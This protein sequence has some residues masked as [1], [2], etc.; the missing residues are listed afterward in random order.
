ML[1]FRGATLAGALVYILPTASAQI[2]VAAGIN[3][4]VA[5]QSS[6]WAANATADKSID[7]NRDGRWAS[8]SMNHTNSEPNAWLKSTFAANELVDSVFVWN[9]LD[10]LS[11][12]INPFSVILRDDASNIVW[13]S[14]G[15]IF[16]DNIDDGDVNTAGMRFDFAPVIARSVTVQLDGTNYLHVAE[17][18]AYQAVPEPASLAVL[19]LVAYAARRRRK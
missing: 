18:E 12:R 19:G 3:G 15:N 8:N 6:L 4:G 9:R 1:K 5:A 13:Q 17:L 2:N 14:N 7:G 11:E 10:G 16:V